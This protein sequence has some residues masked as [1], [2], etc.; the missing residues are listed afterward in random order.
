MIFYRW[1][2]NLSYIVENKK[3]YYYKKKQKL[4][5]AKEQIFAQKENE[6]NKIID[7]SENKEN[8]K[9]K[10]IEF[11]K[12][13]INDTEK[14][15]ELENEYGCY[16]NCYIGEYERLRDLNSVKMK[17]KIFNFIKEFSIQISN[18]NFSLGEILSFIDSLT[19]EGYFGNSSINNEIYNNAVPVAGNGI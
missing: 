3:N 9:K 2:K 18:Y 19:E 8:Q 1:F 10:E 7:D 16:L 5:S 6:E 12:I 13:M 14:V 11:S 17:R 4:L 15:K